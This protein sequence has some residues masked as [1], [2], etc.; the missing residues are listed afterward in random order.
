MTKQSQSVIPTSEEQWIA[1]Y[2]QSRSES[3]DWNPESSFHQ[4]KR[5]AGAVFDTQTY[6]EGKCL[7]CGVYVEISDKFLLFPQR[8]DGTRDVIALGRYRDGCDH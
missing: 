2:K 4:A 1:L 3:G 7:I 5:K 8:R 6:R